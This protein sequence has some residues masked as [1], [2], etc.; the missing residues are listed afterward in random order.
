MDSCLLCNKTLG[1]DISLSF[2]LSFKS[3]IKK[4]VCE[5][6]LSRFERIDKTRI[7]EA[8]GRQ[9][10]KMGICNDCQ[11]W[12]RLG[13]DF[14][15]ESI[16][17]YNDA[18][19]DFMHR[20]KFVGDYQLRMIF[21]NEIRKKIR[22]ELVVVPIPISSETKKERGFNQVIGL[23][24]DVE[25]VSALIVNKK[26]K[27]RQSTL[28]RKERIHNQ[29]VFSIDEKAISKIVNQNVLLVDDIY[30][31]GTTI[32]HAATVLRQNGVQHVFGLTLCR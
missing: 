28:N 1:Y 24:G 29:Q 2:L 4:Y 30:T 6:C 9:M 8:C 23:L 17:K 13:D 3:L 19:K 31:T 25:Y 14:V 18:M 20:Y 26:H 10:D 5:E 11:K 21:Q 16:F 22:K 12:H 27:T 15:N 7:C 32:R